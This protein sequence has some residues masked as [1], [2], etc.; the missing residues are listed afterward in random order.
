MASAGA[1]RISESLFTVGHHRIDQIP[2]HLMPG[3]AQVIHVAESEK[4]VFV[5]VI[6]LYIE[7]R[8]EDRAVKDSP[9]ASVL[10]N[11]MPIAASA[12]SQRIPP[13]SVPKGFAR[14]RPRQ[15]D[16]GASIGNFFRSK[17]IRCAT[18]TLFVSP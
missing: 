6:A 8:E 7:L 4:D 1:A 13:C 9:G 15:P 18:G 17:P 2:V 5:A 16:N 14:C 10:A 3:G 11:T 12:M